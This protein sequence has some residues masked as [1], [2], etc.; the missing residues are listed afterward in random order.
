MSMAQFTLEGILWF[1]LKRLLKVTTSARQTS[2]QGSGARQV[3]KHN[4]V[5]I[6]SA[7]HY[8]VESA[9]MAVRAI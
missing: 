5:Q 2:R 9:T 6:R 7:L 3:C 8:S 4:Y 1:P